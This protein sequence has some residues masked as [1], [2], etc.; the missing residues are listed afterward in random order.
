M[1]RRTLSDDMVIARQLQE[2][3]DPHA[4]VGIQ[5]QQLQRTVLDRATRTIHPAEEIVPAAVI[6]AIQIISGNAH[7]LEANVSAS[8]AFFRE[9]RLQFAMP[10]TC[11]ERT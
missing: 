5:L 10:Q 6:V 8:I 9:L 7:D 3:V 4:A 11:A 1:N 2:A